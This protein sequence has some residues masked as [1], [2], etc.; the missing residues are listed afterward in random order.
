MGP[1]LPFVVGAS[2][3]LA[4][5]R[6]RIKHGSRQQ[7][8]LQVAQFRFDEREVVAIVGSFPGELL[9]ARGP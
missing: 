5:E 8:F 3:A 2:A 9:H 1:W 7:P 6:A 4:G